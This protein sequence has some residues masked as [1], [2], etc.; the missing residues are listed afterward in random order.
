MDKK[1]KVA[2][3]VLGD[4]GRSPR[5]QNH[6]KSFDLTG[7]YCVDLI[8]YTNSKIHPKILESSN[9]T[10]HGLIEAPNFQRIFPRP[11]A[12]LARI[13]WQAASLFWVL[14]F[15]ISSPDFILV[16]NP[17]SVPSLP[18]AWFVSLIRSSEFVI[19]WHNYGFTILSLTTKPNSLSVKIYKW[20]EGTFGR[21][22]SANFAVT[23]AFTRDLHVRFGIDPCY[24]LYDKPSDE[25]VPISLDEIHS[26]LLKL[27]N[28]Y[29]ALGSNEQNETCLTYQDP[30][31]GLIHL[32]SNRPALLISSTSWTEDEDFSILLEALRRYDQFKE[33]SDLKIPEIICI[34]TGKG[35]LKEF[36]QRVINDFNFKHVKFVLP[37]L[38]P[39]DYPKLLACCDLGISLHVS[40][41]SLDL[42][43]KILDMFGSGIPVCAYHYDSLK[44]LV[45]D[46]IN[47]YTFRSSSQLK[48]L[49]VKLLCQLAINDKETSD[50]AKMKRNILDKYTTD[51]WHENW[52][53]GTFSVFG[54]KCQCSDSTGDE[55]DACDDDV[56]CDLT[57]GKEKNN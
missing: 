7:D 6:A 21:K 43:M 30:S 20:I 47:G 38:E 8:G 36:Y 50:L 3:V 12:W 23:E 2:I 42:P 44:E 51:R 1:K 35:P 24:L 52:K 54:R 4:I 22:A 49:L 37:W 10:V 53:K 55:T 56:L 28:D 39:M 34:I 9:I 18:I 5:M 14:T 29:P 15:S 45:Q 25:F 26:L 27:S 13:T 17:P 33:S 16:Q 19:D 57:S 11:L 32:K 40:S 46:G 41:S 48:E 31:D